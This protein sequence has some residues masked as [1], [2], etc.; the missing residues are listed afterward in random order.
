MLF[1]LLQ[2]FWHSAKSR[3]YNSSI[4]GCVIRMGACTLRYFWGGGSADYHAF[5]P[6]RS[7]HILGHIVALLTLPANLDRLV[8]IIKCVRSRFFNTLAVIKLA[9]IELLSCSPVISSVI[10]SR[11]ASVTGIKQD[12]LT[13]VQGF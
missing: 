9:V 5:V 4:I 2:L 11:A 12:D 10:S 8:A 7:C 1:C 3:M 13:P 6:C